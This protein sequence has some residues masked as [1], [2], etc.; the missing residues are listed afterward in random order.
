M[1]NSQEEIVRIALI[2]IVFALIF[3][4]CFVVSVLTSEIEI[5][6]NLRPQNV[7]V[8]FVSESNNANNADEPENEN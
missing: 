2:K 1:N 5:D 3:T 8:V 7:Y 6:R 4:I